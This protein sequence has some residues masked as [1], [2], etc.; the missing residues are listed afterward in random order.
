MK[1]K[2]L[3]STPPQTCRPDADLGTIANVMWDHDCGFVPLIDGVGKVVG[4]ITDRDICI[5]TATRHR[6]PENISAAETT[7]GTVHACGPD[8]SVSDALATMREFKVRRLPVVDGTG[9]LQG[10]ISMNDIVRASDQ[11]RKPP[12]GEV[13]SAMAVI[14]ARRTTETIAASGV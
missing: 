9:Q 2:D 11:K 7:T 14:C 4:V 3:M 6:P 12:P 1:V 13:V 5:A 8:D 10:I